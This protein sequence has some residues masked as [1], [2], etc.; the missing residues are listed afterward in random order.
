MATFRDVKIGDIVVLTNNMI[1]PI[2]TVAVVS[3][4]EEPEYD[5]YITT[6]LTLP[7]GSVSWALDNWYEKQEVLHE[8]ADILEQL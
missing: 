3:E 4:L 8:A 7:D 1:A 2:G 5:G 6:R